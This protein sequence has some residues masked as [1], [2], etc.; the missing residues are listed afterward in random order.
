MKRVFSYLL[1]ICLPLYLF[2]CGGGS[3][4]GSPSPSGGGTDP[5]GSF[6]TAIVVDP[7]SVTPGN[8]AT[9]YTKVYYQ[10]SLPDS[11]TLLVYTTGTTDT[12]GKL[13]NSS[14]QLI[15]YDDDSGPEYNFAIEW[16]LTAGTYYM[17][18]SGWG[19]ET[20]SFELYVGFIDTG[21]SNNGSG[22][23]GGS[24]DTAIVVDPVS[25]TPGNIA[26]S[27][28]KV[29]Y[30]VSLPDSG[31]LLAYTT[32]TTDTYGIL[33]NSS[34]QMITSDDDSG[35]ELNFRI[36]REVAAGTYYIEVSG[37][38]LKTGSYML[39]LEFSGSSQAV[40]AAAL[41]PIRFEDNGDGTITDR[42]TGLVGLN[43]ADCFGP[44]DWVSAK[45]MIKA[46]N[47]DGQAFSCAEYTA[48]HQDWRLPSIGELESLLSEGGP[49]YQQERYWSTSLF[50]K[51]KKMKQVFNS[52]FGVTD[53]EPHGFPGA[54][55]WPVRKP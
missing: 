28:A 20:G 23:A 38:E 5:G 36:E 17:E 8:I 2:A 27:Y 12:Y 42:K 14:R 46:F 18:V 30:Q 53:G 48:D 19:E 1:M 52:M 55:A 45:A 31:T 13:Y 37:Y 6:D 50:E 39:H 54:R 21:G 43:D 33:Y 35:S 11:G 40:A 41:Q 26:T 29:Y 51:N 34:Q 25:I 9:R 22:N 15:A 47:S 24:F 4:S 7:V 49:G 32:G 16:E 3:S 44:V 10:V